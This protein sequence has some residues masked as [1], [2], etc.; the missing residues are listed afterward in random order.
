MK[1]S[2]CEKHCGQYQRKT[3]TR[4]YKPKNYHAI[5]M[6]HAYGFCKENN[7]RCAEVKKCSMTGRSEE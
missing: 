1:V 7:L 6:T 5:G 4:Y 3:W 2:D